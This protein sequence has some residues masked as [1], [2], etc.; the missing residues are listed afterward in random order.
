MTENVTIIGSGPAGFTAGIY[1][2]RDGFDPLL[3]TGIE[4]G[5]QLELTSLVENYPAFPDGIL[6]PELMD[7][8]QDH[9]RKFGARFKSDHVMGI[10]FDTYPY[11]ILGGSGTI[12]TRSMIIATGST[13][14][15]LGIPTEK[16]YI[17]RGVS[18]CAT[19]DAPFFKGK[20]VVVVGGGDSAMEDSLFLTRFAK[21][22]TIVH[23]R[24]SFKASKIMQDRVLSN[25]KIS[26]LLESEVVEVKGE[27][28]VG[29]VAIRNIVNG[30]IL[31]RP[32]Q[33]MFVAIG[34]KPNT[35]FLRGKLPLNASGYVIARD[36][37][38]TAYDGVFVAGDVADPKYRQAITAAGS[39]CK[40]AL[41]VRSFLQEHH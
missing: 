34:H 24:K 30:E 25:P 8:M 31:D 21:S 23:R 14:R 12:E 37:V 32:V 39:G 26:V 9:A 13:A 19:C 15:W 10:D 6:G 35:D 16:K 40:A 1:C 41:E 29:S 2:G 22:V 20:D 5:G 36:E 3:I 28:V 18:S 27:R 38:K 4:V 7:R 17:G 33:G 11:K